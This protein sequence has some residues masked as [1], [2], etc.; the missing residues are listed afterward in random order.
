MLMEK[1]MENRMFCTTKLPDFKNA[2]HQTG[3]QALVSPK[4]LH[5]ECVSV[6][7]VWEAELAVRMGHLEASKVP[8][9][10]SCFQQPG[11]PVPCFTESGVEMF[12]SESWRMSRNEPNVS[13]LKVPTPKSGASKFPNSGRSSKL[14]TVFMA[15]TGISNLALLW[16]PNQNGVCPEVRAAGAGA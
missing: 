3:G 16:K 8:K 10:R 2:S 5:G 15:E 11:L 13:N 1:P 14:I 4:M 6:G 12:E 9:I 7:C